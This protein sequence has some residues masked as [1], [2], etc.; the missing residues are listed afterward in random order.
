MMNDFADKTEYDNVV[1]AVDSMDF[2][3]VVIFVAACAAIAFN[4]VGYVA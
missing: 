1:V 2:L 3:T 4:V